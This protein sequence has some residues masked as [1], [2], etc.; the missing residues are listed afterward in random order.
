MCR[1]ASGPVSHR[2]CGIARKTTAISTGHT[3]GTAEVG[4]V[5]VL[6]APAKEAGVEAGDGERT[7][8]AEIGPEEGT[9]DLKIAVSPIRPSAADV[10]EHRV[11]HM[12]YRNW[13][14]QCVADEDWENSVG[15]TPA[16]HTMYLVWA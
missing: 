14:P 10:A 5:D 12:P 11:C 1:A 6:I 13:C 7:G 16:G 2:R 9:A 8:S 3:V 4:H 15:G